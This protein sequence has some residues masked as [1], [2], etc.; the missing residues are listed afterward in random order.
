MLEEG[1]GHLAHH[2]HEQDRLS[3]HK[4]PLPEPLDKTLFLDTIKSLPHNIFRIK[5]VVDLEDFK[6]PMLFQYVGGRFEFS[7][8]KNPKM[9]DRFV[10]LIGQ[11]IQKEWIDSGLNEKFQQK[12][13]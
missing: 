11:D 1:E 4:I 3:S 10:I 13:S 6:Q 12:N 2:S 7:Q 9:E 5:G 8:F